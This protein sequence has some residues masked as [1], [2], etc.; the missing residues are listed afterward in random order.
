[1]VDLNELLARVEMAERNLMEY[2][3]AVQRMRTLEKQRTPTMTRW[4]CEQLL[5]AQ[6]VV[7]QLTAV[8]ALPVIPPKPEG[9]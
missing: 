1:M 6:F 9:M 3:Q 2:A 7:D 8:C 4:E 5:M